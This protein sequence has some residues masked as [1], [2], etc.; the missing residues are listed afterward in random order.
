MA[1]RHCRSEHAHSHF[2]ANHWWKMATSN[3]LE[4]ILNSDVDESKI[5]SLVGSLESK[6]ASPTIREPIVTNSTNV[7]NSNHISGSDESLVSSLSLA[8]SVCQPHTN[9][10][11]SNPVLSLVSDHSKQATTGLS[12]KSVNGG[13]FTS[14]QTHLGHVNSVVSTLAA[15]SGSNTNISVSSAYA[16]QSQNVKVVSVQQNITKSEPA[17]VSNTVGSTNV[18]TVQYVNTSG[19]TV[20]SRNILVGS[21]P[22]ST[23]YDQKRIT[24]QTI[25]SDGKPSVTPHVLPSNVITLQNV[26]S[27]NT[28]PKQLVQTLVKQDINQVQGG[29][30]V[31]STGAKHEIKYVTQSGDFSQQQA[32]HQNK[33][34]IVTSQGIAG[35]VLKSSTMT[36]GS[37]ATVITRT[38]K[39]MLSP[40][41]VTVLRA[42]ITSQTQG[43]PQPGQQTIQIVN[44][45]N[46]SI[47]RASAPRS[48]ALGQQ[49]TLAPR[50]VPSGLTIAPNIRPTGGQAVVR[51]KYFSKH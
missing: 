44:V 10:S 45:S 17:V 30:L 15:S 50:I 27:A 51:N 14:S 11:S 19:G 1:R 49:R 2:S 13:N 47:T 28:Q 23:I 33:N 39:P 38:T 46:G 36:L 42:P 40:Q 48:L 35:N 43:V 7:L 34:Q 9:L 18:G 41:T 6:L 3:Q 5:L 32:L 26:S 37:G 24:V 22:T 16:N 25:K 4:E 21:Q 31:Q 12:V 20:V 8:Q 29:K